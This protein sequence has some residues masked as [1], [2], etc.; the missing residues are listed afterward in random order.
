MRLYGFWRSSAT[1]RVRIALQ[2]K[3]LPYEYLPIHL[4]KEGGEQHQEAHRRRNP[5]E[6]V[7]ALEL[8]DGVLLTQSL[9]IIDY[10]EHLAPTPALYPADPLARAHVL[11]LAEVINSGIQPMQNLAVTQR[12][13]ELG[14]DAEAWAHGFIGRGLLALEMLAKPL[15]GRFL[16]GDTVTLADVCLAPQMATARRF[17]VD[18][19]AMPTLTRVD[20]LY[21]ELPAFIAAHADQQSD[22]V[23]P[24][25][26]STP[27]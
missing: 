22:A 15:A 8:D 27:N 25:G 26:Q 18:L 3:A 19:S 17:K 16:A 2:L 23:R 21:A 4:T 9:A 10:L 5:M 13:T 7:P 1:W 20:A 6:Q 24:T 12:V 14:G 11:A